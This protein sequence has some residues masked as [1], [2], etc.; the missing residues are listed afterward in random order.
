LF[1]PKC[2]D[3][4]FWMLFNNARIPIQLNRAAVAS[5]PKRASIFGLFGF[6]PTL[7]DMAGG[8]REK[9]FPRVKKKRCAIS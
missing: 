6:A 7:D 1:K 2:G 8:Y 5:D 4:D 9:P 3:V